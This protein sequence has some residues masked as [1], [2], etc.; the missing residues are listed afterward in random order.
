MDRIEKR[1]KFT[2][3]GTAYEHANPTP[4]LVAGSVRRFPSG[5]EP[6]VIAQ[7]PLAGGGTV[8]VHGYATH[9][10]QEWVS[11]EWNDDNIQHFACWV[12]AADVRRPGEDEWRGRYVAF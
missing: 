7:V 9:Y 5:T 12:P 1:T 2:L 11:I 3:D 6:R 8:E 10:T 4:Q